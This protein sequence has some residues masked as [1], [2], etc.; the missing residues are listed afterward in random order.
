MALPLHYD[1]IIIVEIRMG[2]CDLTSGIELYKI[3]IYVIHMRIYGKVWE[4]ITSEQ[5]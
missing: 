4:S 1:Y 2:L 3:G 5:P